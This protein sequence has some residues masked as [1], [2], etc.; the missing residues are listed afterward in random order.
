MAFGALSPA[1]WQYPFEFSTM[2]CRIGIRCYSPGGGKFQAFT[3]L[4]EMLSRI[5]QVTLQEQIPPRG[6]SD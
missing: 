6:K 4:Y 5:R 3:S 2:L 1:E